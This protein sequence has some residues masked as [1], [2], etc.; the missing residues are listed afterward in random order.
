MSRK[1]RPFGTGGNGMLRMDGVAPLH[2]GKDTRQAIVR[3]WML[4]MPLERLSKRYGMTRREVR[5]A[6][7]KETGESI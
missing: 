1:M 4:G 3:D 6:I 5:R 7:K 2:A